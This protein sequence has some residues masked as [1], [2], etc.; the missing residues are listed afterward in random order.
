MVEESKQLNHAI[1][2]NYDLIK[3][4]VSYLDKENLLKT[5][6]NVKPPL[7]NVGKDIAEFNE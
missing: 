1:K 7:Q 2:N 5:D 4:V 6:L 3:P